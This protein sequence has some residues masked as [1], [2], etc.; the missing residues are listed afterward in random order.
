MATRSA[1]QNNL[2][3]L[4]LAAF[5]RAPEYSGYA[6]WIDQLGAGQTIQQVAGTVFSL[7]G[8]LAIYPE[9][10]SN[11]D[12]VSR[13]YQNVFGKT[14]DT[15]GIFYWRNHLFQG[16]SRGEL[17]LNMINA[18]LNT[19][20]TTPGKAYIANRYTAAQYAV[21]QQQMLSGEITPEALLAAMTS[22]SQSPQTLTNYSNQ[23]R[24]LALAAAGKGFTYFTD[25]LNESA[26]N[27]GSFTD[28]ITIRLSGDTFKGAV[29]DK[30][31]TVSKV[32]GGLTATLTKASDVTAI[33]ALSGKATAHT[34]A[35]D[36]A[37]LTVTFA[38]ADLVSGT[39][40]DLAGVTRND[41]KI[42][43]HD[44][45]ISET[46]GVISGEGALPANLL[47]DLVSDR[48]TLGGISKIPNSGNISNA[49][50]ID[51]GLMG[52]PPT[53]DTKAGATKVT[54]SATLLG[55][56]QANSL[57]ASA[58]GDTL[59]G[60]GG[61]DTLKGST[62]I[63][64]FIF[65]DSAANNGIDT[66]TGVTLGTG[67]DVLNFKA[68]LDKTGTGNIAATVATA[69]TAVIASPKAWSNGDVLV[70]QGNWLNTAADIASLFG[71]S[72]PF[73]A[74]TSSAK[75]V[76]ITTDI[77]GSAKVW[78]ITNQTDLTN[79]SADEIQQVATLDSIH[80]LVLVGFNAA[81]FA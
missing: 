38:N 69:P 13:I 50:S 3:K 77:I 74:P 22:V 24:Q 18:G 1:D 76:I 57:A 12:F 26:V 41:L 33:L 32:P 55:D 29:G 20:D 61:N 4:Y 68:F 72:H 23:I 9:A 44:L 19:P 63:D 62:G 46:S 65:A 45:F 47:I 71:A 36:I 7:E 58:Y 43:F 59:E 10:L 27:D 67:G 49:H 78:Y 11:T 70:V 75:A 31:G 60:R 5:L 28:T 54:V 80:N 40:A 15:D 6:Y 64:R 30:L 42:I 66:I 8:V 16:V 2:I 48:M 14:G 21:E 52:P 25:T 37:N 79:I 34:E 53:T 17:V 35:N 73:A 51:L 56:S 39:T 81:N